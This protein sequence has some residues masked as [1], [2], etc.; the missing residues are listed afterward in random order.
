MFERCVRGLVLAGLVLAVCCAVPV[1]AGAETCGP[2]VRAKDLA[3]FEATIRAALA[4]GDLPIIDVEHHWGGKKDMT[5]LMSKMD[6]NGVALTWLGQNERLGSANALTEHKA[7]PGRIVPTSIHGDG[8][9]WHGRDP[10]LL[11]ELAKDMRSG[12][13]YAMGEFE[14]R[15]YPSGTNDRD[16]HLPLDSASFEAVFALAQETGAPF[17][18]HHEAEDTLLPEME[19]MLAKYPG[20]K[21]V[22]CHVGRNRNGNTWTKF[23]TPD[24][25]RAFLAKY[26]NLHFDLNQAKPGGRYRLTNAVD[27][28]FYEGKDSEA[29]LLS[30]WKKVFEEYPDRFVIGTDVNTGRWDDYERVVDTFRK[31]VLRSLSKPTAEKIAWKNAWRLMAGSEW[32]D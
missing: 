13:Y 10:S 12:C 1:E 22:W 24:G 9:R 27:A 21:V 16:V 3:A 30:S 7:Y 19:R 8:P 14:A 15:H 23:P 20:A 25:V 28:V 32:K 2:E 31:V 4:K 17:L 5:A 18:I 26:P 6:K 29:N 11:E